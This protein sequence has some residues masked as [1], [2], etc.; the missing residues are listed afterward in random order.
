MI[1]AEDV[2]QRDF[3]YRLVA[4]NPDGVRR[5]IMSRRSFGTREAGL[6]LDATANR[7][8]M[9]SHVAPGARPLKIRLDIARGRHWVGKKLY[10][11]VVGPGRDD[12]TLLEA[13][14]IRVPSAE[15]PVVSFEVK[16]KGDW[17]FLRI[18]D[19]NRAC[20]PLGKAPFED[21]RY[22]GAVAYTSPWFFTHA[23]R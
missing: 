8:A 11:Q 2:C 3:A 6:R 12:P 4:S 10:V 13:F 14:P 7:V 20:D 23:R 1:S 16:P 22:G 21:A 19:P 9:G 15:Q 5:A 18:T 17:M